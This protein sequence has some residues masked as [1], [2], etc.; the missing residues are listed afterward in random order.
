ML[1][2]TL[3]VA[4]PAYSGSFY[5]STLQK[6]QTGPAVQQYSDVREYDAQTGQSGSRQSTPATKR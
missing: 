1:V 5:I 4:A 3:V 2:A 6:T